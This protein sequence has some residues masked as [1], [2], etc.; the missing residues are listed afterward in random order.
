MPRFF[1]RKL[2]GDNCPHHGWS[3]LLTFQQVVST[4]A[5][6]NQDLLI[7]QPIERA[8]FHSD[9]TIPRSV[10]REITMEIE[11]ARSTYLGKQIANTLSKK[12]YERWAWDG[13]TK[14]GASFVTSPPDGIGMIKDVE[15]R[16]IIATY[17]GQPDPNL[18]ALVGRFFGK[19]GDKLDEYGANLASAC[20]PG[21]GFRIIH[22]KQQDLIVS[23]MKLAGIHSVKEAINFLQGKVGDPFMKRYAEHLTSQEGRRNAPHAIIPDIHAINYPAGKQTVNDSGATHCAEAFFEIK[24]FQPNNTRYN[25]NNTKINP[26]DRRAKE[27]VQQYSRKF[28][29]LD[30]N[31]AQEVVGDGRNGIVGPFEAAQSQFFGGQVIPVVVGA[32]GEVNK[33]FEKMLRTLAKLASS[34]EDG[35]S[36]SPLRNLDKKGGAFAI[37]HHQFR[38]AVGVTIVRD[39]ANHKLSRLHYVRAT[40]ADAKNTAEANHSDNR[41]W[42][43]GQQG[44]SGWYSQH[45]PGGYA[46]YE[47]FRN[48]NYFGTL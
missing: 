7:N 3:H 39:M 36:I 42:N 1:K 23:M 2:V 45:T 26:A 48:G 19:K 15:W 31:Y 24:S 35:M 43:R 29:K 9:G 37:M 28:H 21:A 14:L 34:G 44:R 47:Q 10:T 18:A 5:S 40:E 25:H 46:N 20:L 17:L 27:V 33:D 16:T 13:W 32:F 6:E 11:S 30:Q 12:H 38:R 4:E 41:G 8:G 22:N